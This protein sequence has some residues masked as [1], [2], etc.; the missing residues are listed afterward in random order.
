V[1]GLSI[2]SKPEWRDMDFGGGYKVSYSL[3]GPNILVVTPSGLA[4]R[5]VL[6]KA[7]VA[8]RKLVDEA[9]AEGN[10]YVRIEDWRRL[11]KASREARRCYADY[12]RK[13]EKLL[14]LILYGASP[15]L[16]LAIKLG[17]RM[18]APDFDVELA[19]SYADAV[20]I[21]QRILSRAHKKGEEC[22]RNHAGQMPSAAAGKGFIHDVVAKPEWHLQTDKFSLT[23][24]VING[25]ILHGI[26][27]GRLEKEH[28]APSTRMQESVTTSMGLHTKPYCYVLGLKDSKG[29]G[30]RARKLYV[31][32]MLAL[33]KRYPFRMFVFYGVNKTLKAGINLARPFVPFK[34]RIAKDLDSALEMTA[35]NKFERPSPEPWLGVRNSPGKS[36][37]PHQIGD[38]VKEL[39]LFLDAINWES[40]GMPV[41]VERDPSHPFASVFDAIELVKWELDDLLKEKVEREEELKRAK[42]L[43]EKAN[44]TKSEFLANMSH[45]LRTPLNH[46]IGFTELVVDKHFGDLNEM[47][48][49]YLKDVLQSGRRLLF[50]INEILDFSSAEAGKLDLDISHVD[51]RRLLETGIATIRKEALRKSLSLDADL[52][53]IPQAIRGDERKLKHVIHN[54][55][56]NAL[57]FTP[58]GGKILLSAAYVSGPSGEEDRAL[59][60]ISVK[61]TGIGLRQDDQERI[62]E[63]FEQVENATNRRF[64]GTGLGLALTKRLVEL[65][66]GRIWVES[67]GEGKG[68]TFCFT[69]PTDIGRN[70]MEQRR[71]PLVEHVK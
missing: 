45:E 39:L 51:V 21:A 22:S 41:D 68:S 58:D 54:L 28:I 3:L 50:L 59:I 13:N 2:W 19:G 55:L 36:S 43:A 63:R 24:E 70:Q 9:V 1:S 40:D 69:L 49:N 20:G 46:I 16:R 38:Y 47:Q 30:Q 23:F 64:Q 17:K 62:F 6:E 26:A 71:H 27:G 52:D 29:T 66:G 14:G 60:Q 5:Q 7:I 10:R 34:V 61:D 42:E 35:E 48:E 11:R 53:D 8:D 67:D 33:Y 18:I 31:E 37:G 32:A 56:S 44:R 25:R 4:T 65:H 12:V 15:M 57:K